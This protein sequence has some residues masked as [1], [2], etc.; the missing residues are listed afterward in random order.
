M[1]ALGIDLYSIIATTPYPDT[2]IVTGL[3]AG[4][5]I[6]VLCRIAT[7][8]KDAVFVVKERRAPPVGDLDLMAVGRVD[9]ATALVVGSE[10]LGAHAAELRNA[11]G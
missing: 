4:L 2:D 5:L 7:I 3:M 8:T 11:E 6:G 10:S 9:S 1:A